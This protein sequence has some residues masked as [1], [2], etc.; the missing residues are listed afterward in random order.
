MD[1]REH[2]IRSALSYEDHSFTASE[3]ICFPF[4][5]S[6]IRLLQ[7]SFLTCNKALKIVSPLR[8][9]VI[10]T[11]KTNFLFCAFSPGSTHTLCRLKEMAVKIPFDRT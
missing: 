7:Q 2:D 1:Y 6:L 8:T 9:N 11:Q 3:Y 4:S 5:F 10:S